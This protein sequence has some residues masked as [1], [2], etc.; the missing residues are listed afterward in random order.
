[1]GLR[2]T[3]LSARRSVKAPVRASQRQKILGFI[4]AKGSDGATIEEIERGMKM[5][6]N[7]V[8]PRRQEL[9]EMGIVLDSGRR[10]KTEKGRNAIVWVTIPNLS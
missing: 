4:H 2:P 8:R 3:S 1:M 7:T 9:E 5:S 10:R 6:G